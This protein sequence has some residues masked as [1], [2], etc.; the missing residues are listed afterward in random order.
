MFEIFEQRV[1]YVLLCSGEK[2]IN[3]QLSGSQISRRCGP[4]DDGLHLR[5]LR[6]G[7]LFWLDVG[8][9]DQLAARSEPRLDDLGKLI[10]RAGRRRK[11]ERRKL[12]LHLGR[13]QHL[14]DGRVE[15]DH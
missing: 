3:S 9:P 4:A 2:K 10:G 8:G 1:C 12:L 11:A 5:A 14:A 15:T 13:V 6:F 7:K